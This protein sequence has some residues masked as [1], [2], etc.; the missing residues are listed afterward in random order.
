M[1][2][3]QAIGEYYH[4]QIPPDCGGQSGAHKDVLSVTGYE[5]NA[6]CR[7]V[8]A[9]QR[10]GTQLDLSNSP[11]GMA[12]RS[13]LVKHPLDFLD[14]AGLEQSQLQQNPGLLWI[15]FTS[16]DEAQL[17]VIDLDVTLYDATADPG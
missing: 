7:E 4:G 10:S 14:I 5:D 9:R 11:A 2:W 12:R 8:C 16:C 15:E 17:V 13:V 3:R 6:P 1:S